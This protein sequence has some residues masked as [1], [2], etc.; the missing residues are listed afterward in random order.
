MFLTG[1][2][3]EHRRRC[4]PAEAPEFFGAAHGQVAGIIRHCFGVES[5]AQMSD[6]LGGLSQ[7][8]KTSP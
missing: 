3:K 6:R 1:A 4:V 8:S 2:E 7:W 5:S